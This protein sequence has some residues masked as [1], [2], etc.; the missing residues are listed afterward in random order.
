M[1][2]NTPTYDP[3][4]RH[5]F[6]GDVLV[7]PDCSNPLSSGERCCG[8][9]GTGIYER[10]GILSFSTESD[11]SDPYLSEH[12]LEELAAAVANHPVRTAAADVLADRDRSD[13]LAELFDVRRDL[14]QVLVA[15]HIS[16]RCLD[17]YSGY[18][19]R[20]MVLA[21][22]TDA[23]YTV[24]PSLS[25]LRI[26]DDRDDYASSDRVVPIHTT[27]RR[28]PFSAGAFD[29]IVAD[30]TG[31]RDLRSRLDRLTDC[32][33]ADGS[34][35]F[36]A[37]GWPSNTPLARVLGFDRADQESSR[38]IGDLS[39]GTADGYRSLARS[40]GFDDISVYTLFPDASRPLYAFDVDSDR[41]LETILSSHSNAY[42]RFGD[43]IEPATRR[44][45][46][47]VKQCYPTYLVACTNSP[48]PPAFEFSDPLVVQGRT[49]TVVLNLDESGIDTVW[50]I[51]NR[52]A[53]RPY[54][55]NEN[56]VI[57]ELR[58]REAPI[59]STLPAGEALESR[60]GPVRKERPV[61]GTP[62]EEEI[63]GGVESFERVLRLSFDWLIDFQRAFR[64]ESFVRSADAVR[65]DL[66][67]EP[68][69]LVASRIDE[70]VETFTTPVH[71]DYMPGNIHHEDGEITSVIDWEYGSL[72]ASPVVD[73]G[74][75]LLNVASWVVQNFRERVRTI[76]CRRNEYSRRVRS[77]VRDYCDAVGLPYRSFELYL[78]AAYLHRIVRD[79]ELDAVRTY[80]RQL[81]T[82]I[83]R[84]KVLLDVRDEM[85]IS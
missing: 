57:A 8:S 73:A 75:L 43:A 64:S 45:H 18:G 11:D 52:N 35:I 84:T 14:W 38:S 32:L 49:R 56:A 51:P 79:R 5:E 50:K 70:D 81:D 1:S 4:S 36:T 68:A 61:D 39:P 16:G 59:T 9:C 69:D 29:T 67:F 33:A 21:E 6:P 19:R 66:T 26:V 41:A 65:E 40:V 76:L 48:E 77:C 34:L 58:S 31:K 78:P 22:R 55:S 24:D 23:V 80:T 44:G 47:L 63:D 25:K 17:L 72:A 83:R 15:E 7:C 74:F 2:E 20:A 28:L 82:T 46:R 30:F 62:L 12:R 53:H 37:D 42:D 27:D 10:K 71:G 60:F 54:T 13:A 3:E 85:I